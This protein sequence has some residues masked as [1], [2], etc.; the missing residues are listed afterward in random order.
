MTEKQPRVKIKKI[1]KI[2]K[3]LFIL[4]IIYLIGI[5]L[6]YTP[7]ELQ[8]SYWEFR[9]MCELNE[10][11]NNEEKYNKILKY[12]NTDLESLDWE[13]LNKTKRI[14][15]A[16][17]KFEILSRNPLPDDKYRYEYIDKN[18]FVINNAPKFKDITAI[19]VEFYTLQPHINRNNIADIK[20]FVSWNTK[21]Y[22]YDL[23]STSYEWRK[24]KNY[25]IWCD[26]IEKEI[27][28]E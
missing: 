10:L 1:L 19:I 11:P 16:F 22:R 28:N 13:E 6:Y 9:K 2:C 5:P 27:N 18:R 21:R 14:S 12:F 20:I 15:N 25:E 23:S 4:W 26:D 7:Y 8:P 3:I 24:V 17:Y